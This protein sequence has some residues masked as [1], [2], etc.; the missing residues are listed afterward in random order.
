M[1]RPGLPALGDERGLALIIVLLVLSLLLSVVGEFALAMRLE[2]TTTA[3]FQASVTAT[4][5][6]EAGYQRAVAEILPEAIAHHLD[7]TRLLVFRRTR[8]ETPVA[9]SRRDIALGAGRFSYRISDEEARLNL[10]RASPDILHRLLTELGVER[11][12]RDV[13]VDSI[14]DWR[15]PNEEHRLNGAESEYYLALPV[16]YRSK[17]ADFDT[18]DELLQVRGVTPEIFYGRPESPGLREYLTV[19]GTGAININTASDVVLRTMGFAQPEVDLL[20]AGRPYFDLST[21]SA[22]LRRGA[23]RTRSDTFRIEATG[24]VGGQGRRTLTVLVQRR[25]DRAATG[26]QVATLGWQWKDEEVPR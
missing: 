15:D 1:G 7:E 25:P 5:L 23:Q 6:A 2:G 9:P 8:I 14:L 21:L 3:N 20:K 4:Y 26:V 13:I 16:P 18:V 24:Q 17:N 10:N 11:Q 19:A 22:Q 12:I